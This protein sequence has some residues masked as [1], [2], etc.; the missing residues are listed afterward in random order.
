MK[1]EKNWTHFDSVLVTMY[2]ALCWMG[3]SMRKKYSS[4][5]LFSRSMQCSWEEYENTLSPTLKIQNV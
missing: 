1:Y 2:L 5:G 3:R 4:V